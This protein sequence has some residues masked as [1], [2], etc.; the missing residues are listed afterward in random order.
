[1]ATKVRLHEA[2]QLA[3]AGSNGT[4]SSEPVQLQ[5]LHVSGIVV[6]KTALIEALRVY[7]PALRDV[8]VTEDGEQFWLLLDTAAESE[9]GVDRDSVSA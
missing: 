2:A 5:P 9:K 4:A 8:Q 7:V 3:Q 6:T 1:M